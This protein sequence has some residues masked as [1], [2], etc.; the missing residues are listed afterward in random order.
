MKTPY[1]KECPYF[2]GDYYRGRQFEECRLINKPDAFSNWDNKLCKDCKV[3]GIIMAN[4]CPNMTL[5]ADVKNVFL[6][7]FRKVKVTAYCSKSHSEVKKPEV[8]CGY[9]HR[10]PDQFVLK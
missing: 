6:G 1:G 3:P 5:N 7:L 8:G 4:A 9:C 10:L 2:Y